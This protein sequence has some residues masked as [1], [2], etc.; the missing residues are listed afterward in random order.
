M[1]FGS[2]FS[3]WGRPL[4]SG[5]GPCSCSLMLE[6]P[7]RS[8]CASWTFDP[9]RLRHSS[10]AD[11]VCQGATSSS[12]RTGQFLVRQRHC[13]R[14]CKIVVVQCPNCQSKFRI[15][16]D[17]V[18]DRGVRV[19]CT[20][21]KNVFQVK[22]PGAA[23]AEAPGPGNTMEMSAL[24]AAAVAP[25]AGAARP[26]ASRTAPAASRPAAASRP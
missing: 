14:E 18:T 2:F 8:R 21:C 11:R 4:V 24:G 10:T 25:R 1:T 26:G 9:K 19:R 12:D 5:E 22:K 7:T 15:A 13:G 16:D 23:G 3:A 17:K 20:S 6:T